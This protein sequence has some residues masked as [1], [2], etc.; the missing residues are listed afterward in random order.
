MRRVLSPE[1]FLVPLSIRSNLNFLVRFDPARSEVVVVDSTLNILLWNEEYVELVCIPLLA[2]GPETSASKALSVVDA[3]L[4]VRSDGLH[5][6]VLTR[7]SLF[8]FTDGLRLFAETPHSFSSPEVRAWG[9]NVVVFSSGSFHVLSGGCFRALHISPYFRPITSYSCGRAS[10]TDVIAYQT[11]SYTSIYAVDGSAV[12]EKYPC[13]HRAVVSND[14][15]VFQKNNEVLLYRVSDGIELSARINTNVRAG[16]KW[17]H[18]KYHEGMLYMS[19]VGSDGY[20]LYVDGHLFGTQ[21]LVQSFES[22]RRCF[23]GASASS[24]HFL[25]SDKDAGLKLLDSECRLLNNVINGNFTPHA[26][27]T[28]EFLSEDEGLQ[29]NVRR[30]GHF[31]SFL[32]YCGFKVECRKLVCNALNDIRDDA[33]ALRRL[34]ILSE[35]MKF[36][37]KAYKRFVGMEVDVDRIYGRITEIVDPSAIDEEFLVAMAEASFRDIDFLD[38]PRYLLLK[39]KRLMEQGRGFMA[40]LYRCG[41]FDEAAQELERNN[42][43]VEIVLLWRRVGFCRPES[44]GTLCRHS[45]ENLV[46]QSAAD[47]EISGWDALRCMGEMWGKSKDRQRA[48]RDIVGSIGSRY[49]LV[50]GCALPSGLSALVAPEVVQRCL[51]GSEGTEHAI[52]FLLSNGRGFEASMLYYHLFATTG[53]R[54]SLDGFLANVR[55]RVFVYE[56]R[57]VGREAVEQG[58]RE[59][60]NCKQ[61]VLGNIERVKGMASGCVW[62]CARAAEQCPE[63]Y[64]EYLRVLEERTGQRGLAA[65]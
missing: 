49:D 32:V 53:D 3:A 1:M 59:E 9:E 6:F 28:F 14:G 10:G 17:K 51:A 56:G 43:A 41:L 19:G 61:H 29:G 11:G 65:E 25:P 24:M 4:A 2:Q 60:V 23:I 55:D 16:V 45:L 46:A 50:A 18:L 35:A 40:P 34:R 26:C 44:L 64:R 38:T 62:T 12:V 5:V 30:V 39:G 36:G 58:A 8:H 47:G 15:V 21:E 13:T 20:V 42:R 7:T 63:E 27:R 22:F 57:F 52:L 31:L 54:G 37:H 33:R 48:A